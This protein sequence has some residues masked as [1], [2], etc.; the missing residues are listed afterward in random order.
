MHFY[1]KMNF[2]QFQ[3]L[4]L[5]NPTVFSAR[6]SVLLAR[7][8]VRLLVRTDFVTTLSHER[9][10]S[11]NLDETYWEYSLA[12]DELIIFWRSKVKGHSVTAGC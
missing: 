3:F 6:P 12:S 1:N 5:R 4:C 9:L 11:S 7:S 2:M 10:D 8:F